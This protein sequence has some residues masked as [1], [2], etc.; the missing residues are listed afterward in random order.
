MPTTAADR[1]ALAR[2]NLQDTR[3]KILAAQLAAASREAER[4][5][6]R[7]RAICKRMPFLAAPALKDRWRAYVWV[8]VA[9]YG[10]KGLRD[11]VWP[12]EQAARSQPITPANGLPRSV[13]REMSRASG[14]SRRFLRSLEAKVPRGRVRVEAAV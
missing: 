7:F 9:H 10:T 14:S 8:A 12:W 3:R 2:T 4:A 1:R 5:E 13:R 11:V 6:A